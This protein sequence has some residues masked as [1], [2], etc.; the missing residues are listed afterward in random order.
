MLYLRI[1][2]E[3]KEIPIPNPQSRKACA[4]LMDNSRWITEINSLDAIQQNEYF[5]QIINLKAWLPEEQ[6]NKL[7]L[8]VPLAL[9]DDNHGE[10]GEE[11]EEE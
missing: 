6:T 10:D 9:M 11:E 2:S 5:S 1:L 7:V 8:D 4:N 3:G